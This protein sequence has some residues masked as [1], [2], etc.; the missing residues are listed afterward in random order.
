ML[1]LGDLETSSELMCHTLPQRSVRNKQLRIFMFSQLTAI[2]WCKEVRGARRTVTFTVHATSRHICCIPH[3]GKTLS[4]MSHDESHDVTSWDS[5]CGIGERVLPKT[6][7]SRLWQIMESHDVTYLV[8]YSRRTEDEAA[9]MV[10]HD[11]SVSSPVRYTIWQLSDT[12]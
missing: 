1:V 4:S 5:S 8:L 11:C 3:P 2:L 7:P 12:L 9:H 6:K 10:A